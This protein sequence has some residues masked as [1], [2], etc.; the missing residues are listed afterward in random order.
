MRA[1]IVSRSVGIHH[2]GDRRGERTRVARPRKE[3]RR[4]VARRAGG[5]LAEGD[6]EARRI[7]HQ[8]RQQGQAD[9]VDLVDHEVEGDGDAEV[10]PR[11]THRP[12]QLP[13]LVL[14]GR[15]HRPVSEDDARRD[16]AVDCQ[17]MRA[18]EQPDAAGGRQ[19][20]Y[21]HR[22]AVAGRQRPAARL[23]RGGDL[24]PPGAGAD[25]D[26][27]RGGVEHLDA[28]QMPEVDDDAAIVRRAAAEAVPAASEPEW[29]LHV[30]PGEADCV[31]DLLDRAREQHDAGR[32]AAEVRRRQSTV[33]GITRLH[34]GAGEGRRDGVI[35]QRR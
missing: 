34:G 15:H 13:V 23:Q 33:R 27:P 30:T 4:G 31:D 28:V 9:L 35:V 20:P 32:S 1:A 6:E 5:G 12:E 29:H 11:A 8:V 22:A 19:A 16:E 21:S 7:L 10:R 18:G 17:T 2:D 24:L 25:P 26:E 14:V 3:N